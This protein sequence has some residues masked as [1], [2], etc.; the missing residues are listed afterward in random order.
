[1][2]AKRAASETSVARQADSFRR[3]PCKNASEARSERS[4]RPT[5]YGVRAHI[6]SEMLAGGLVPPLTRG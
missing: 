6:S 1:M 3:Y 5:P 4:E 2:Q